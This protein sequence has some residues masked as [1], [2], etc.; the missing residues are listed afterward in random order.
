MAIIEAQALS[1][2][3]KVPV[4]KTG[5]LAAVLNLFSLQHTRRVAVDQVS[6]TIERGEMVGYVGP[7]GAGK[8]TTIK[9]LTGIL[10]PSEGQV[11]VAGLVPHRERKRLAYSIGV[12]FGQKTQLWWD[13]PVIESLRLLREIYK[14]PAAQYKINLELFNDLLD[15]H[16]F[17]NTPVRQLSL[18]QRM[19]S[20]LVAA[21]LHNP[22]ILFL[23]EPTIGVDVVAKERFRT[24]IQQL[25]QERQVTVLLTTHDLSDIE[26]VCDRLMIIDKGHIIYDGPVAGLKER[27]TPYR[28]LVVD[29]ADGVA[30][31]A[32]DGAELM[33]REG[34]QARF[35]FNRHEVSASELIVELAGKYRVKDISVEEPE[36]ES[37]IGEIYRRSAAGQDLGSSL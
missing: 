35:R 7:N 3:F 4:R 22:A 21:L 9:M 12:V 14:I 31:V 10:M 18:G 30:N 5:R 25:N 13:V 11:K 19:R 37:I 1:K 33:E 20:D 28:V 8:S 6:F 17:Q 26:K 36:I 24:F 32:I 27:V 16:E 15:L 29:F 23:D 2:H 34:Q